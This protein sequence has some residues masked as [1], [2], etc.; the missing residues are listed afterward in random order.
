M[1]SV[2]RSPSPL[3]REDES[4]DKE[5]EGNAEKEEESFLRLVKPIIT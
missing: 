1:N 4:K 2:E 5:E 3:L